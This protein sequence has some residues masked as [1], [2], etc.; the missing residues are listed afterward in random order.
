MENVFFALSKILGFLQFPLTWIFIL[1]IWALFSKNTIRKIKLFKISVFLLY[2]ISNPFL[3]SEFSRLW[4]VE[5]IADENVR[6]HKYAV[7]LSGMVVYDKKLDRTQFFR[8]GDRLIQALELYRK[9]KFEKFILTG[10]SGS[11]KKDDREADFMK[12]FLI[13]ANVPDSAIIIE[14]ESRNTYENAKFTSDILK[15]L[16]AENEEVLLITSSIHMRRSEACFLKAGIKSQVFSTDRITGIRKW[17]IDYLFLPE[18]GAIFAWNA[19]IHETVGFV[20]YK[21]MGYC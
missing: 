13:S 16:K 7:V 11:L 8:G 10:G 6:T 15:T 1:L 2:L 18:A 19:L 3:F 4:E 21:I 20:T 17:D 12:R 5:A 9:G 14:R